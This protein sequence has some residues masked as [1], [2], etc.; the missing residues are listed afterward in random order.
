MCKE[1]VSL[2]RDVEDL[3]RPW[4]GRGVH[5]TMKQMASVG[6]DVYYTRMGYR[7]KCRRQGQTAF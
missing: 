2:L 1:R 5:V 7:H 4:R 6:N 3:Y